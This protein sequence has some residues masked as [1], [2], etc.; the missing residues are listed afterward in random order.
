MA[1]VMGSGANINGR[2]VSAFFTGRGGRSDFPPMRGPLVTIIMP[3]DGRRSKRRC[4]PQSGKVALGRQ[5]RT[6]Y[7]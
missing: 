2:L 4:R 6:R 3:P 1:L 7:N 5:Q